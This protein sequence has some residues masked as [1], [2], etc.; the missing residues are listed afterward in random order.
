MKRIEIDWIARRGRSRAGWLLL[1]IGLGSAVLS[2]E[3][4]LTWSLAAEQF[5]ARSFNQVASERAAVRKRA[6]ARDQ[7]ALQQ[8]VRAANRVIGELNV[9]WPEL[10]R[11]LEAASDSTVALLAIQPDSNGRSLRV[12][13]EARDYPAVLGF[14]RRL[15]ETPAFS[16]VHAASHQTRVEASYRPIGFALVTRWS[17]DAR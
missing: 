5:E 10:F 11:D 9:P 8:E 14:V 16:E 1:A 15:E 4:H 7:A 17:A 6:P 3:R 12:E 13:G 2:V